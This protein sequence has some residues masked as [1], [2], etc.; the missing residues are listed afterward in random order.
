MIF[1]LLWNGIINS[2]LPELKDVLL[3]VEP[4]RTESFS[5]PPQPQPWKQLSP[6]VSVS[7]SPRTTTT[8][9]YTYP[10][11][12][13]SGT[14]YFFDGKY[15]YH[16][17][18]SD[19]R[20]AF[21]EGVYGKASERDDEESLGILYAV[22]GDNKF[23]KNQ[24]LPV[25]KYL[26]EGLGIQDAPERQTQQTQRQQVQQQ[27][28]EG[29]QQ[30]SKGERSRQQW[31]LATEPHLCNGVL[32]MNNSDSVLP[33][34]DVLVIITHEDVQ[35]E[36]PNEVLRNPI[37]GPARKHY[38]KAMKVKAMQSAPF[39]ITI[40]ADV[41]MI[42]CRED[43]G[44]RLLRNTK[45]R[46]KASHN[47]SQFD[48]ALSN[49]NS[50]LAKYDHTNPL[51]YV[52][53]SGNQTIQS[54]KESN[55]TTK[56]NKHNSALVIL[57]TTSVRTI[58]FLHLYNEHFFHSHDFGSH[59][60]TDQPSLGEAMYDVWASYRDVDGGGFQHVDLDATKVC[61][62]RTSKMSGEGVYACPSPAVERSNSNE[63]LLVH[64]PEKN[65][66]ITLAKVS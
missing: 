6:P 59:R 52:H 3:A 12:N 39:P 56:F 7:E 65:N 44:G 47:I 15:H 36:D 33:F 5:Q 46:A 49:V 62:K 10:P 50:R 60:K 11:C 61:R 41:D 30:P 27:Q 37:K 55:I 45:K 31:A 9:V 1:I 63:C 14:Y 17:N 21:R 51:H 32:S 66:P 28:R 23:A 8:T 13:T 29:Q 57:N 38:V 24:F 18:S 16:T 40:F 2:G 64:K 20:R 53:M 42:P 22:T 43:F 26:R 34:F 54:V 4:K 58:E 35:K 48:I 19:F 25:V